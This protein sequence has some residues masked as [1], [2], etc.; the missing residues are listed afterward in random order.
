MRDVE[1]ATKMSKVGKLD[2]RVRNYDESQRCRVESGPLAAR[3][4]L[5]I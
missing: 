1:G 3:I 2:D 4:Q 5:R